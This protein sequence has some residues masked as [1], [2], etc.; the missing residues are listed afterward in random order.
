[1]GWAFHEGEDFSLFGSPPCFLYTQR[2]RHIV[3]F[4]HHTLHCRDLEVKRFPF[5][6]YFWFLENCILS[7]RSL[8]VF[9]YSRYLSYLLSRG[10]GQQWSAHLAWCSTLCLLGGKRVTEH[11]LWAVSLWK[12]GRDWFFYH[13][14]VQHLTNKVFSR[15]LLSI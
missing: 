3:Y 6:E 12:T 8:H 11:L 15:C 14:L 4:L 1:M 5:Q 10:H 7:P 13:L 2:Y 9:L